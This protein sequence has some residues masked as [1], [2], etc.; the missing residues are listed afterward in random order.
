M[1]VDGVS[2][3]L[4]GREVLRDVSFEVRAGELVG[5]I[6]PNGA[7]KTTLMRSILGL[8]AKKTGRVDPQGRV[9]YV[10][11]RHD[12]DWD[13]PISIEDMVIMGWRGKRGVEAFRAVARALDSVDM[14]ALAR[15][16][17]GQ[18]SGGQ[19]QRVLIARA[20]VESPSILL[21]DEPFTGLDQ[22]TQDML[23]NLFRKLAD[24]GTGVLMSTHDLAQ[25]VDVC[26]RLVMLSGEVVASGKPEEL[27]DPVLWMETYR[28]GPQSPLLRTVGLIGGAR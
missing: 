14:R 21:L 9:G 26:D 3:V 13:Y 7:G 8:V 23:S 19:R 11:Q 16:P 22:P 28:V 4:G 2:V 1:I 20:L 24:K 6:G 10:P 17:M 15:R 27:R 25:A 18:L 5:L 12:I